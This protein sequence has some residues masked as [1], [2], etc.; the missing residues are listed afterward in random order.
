MARVTAQEESEVTRSNQQATHWLVDTG[1][2][3]TRFYLFS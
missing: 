2:V 3:I 1:H